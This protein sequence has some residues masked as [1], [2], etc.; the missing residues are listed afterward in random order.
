[1][2]LATPGGE[3]FGHPSLLGRPATLEADRRIAEILRAA[4]Q[5][6]LEVPS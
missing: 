2:A 5:E 1:V 3:A 6:T 4:E